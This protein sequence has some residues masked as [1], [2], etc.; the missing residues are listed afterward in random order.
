MAQPRF[1]SACGAA[2][3][4][5]PPVTCA[6]CGTSHWRNPKPCANAVVVRDGR[7]LLTRRAHQPWNGAW[8]CPGGFVERGEHPIEAAER[9]V[10]EETGVRVRVTGYLGVWVDDYADEP[11]DDDSE[12]INV[13]YYLAE[14]ISAEGGPDPAEV[15]EL[16]WFAWDELP[17]E[18]APPGT[19]EQVLAAA[20]NGVEL[21][22]RP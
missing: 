5:P 20:R 9:E 22:D 16:A 18:L 13:G 1:C 21:A 6:G 3:P 7:V 19:L 2:L 17:V 11:G 14:P 4:A 10:L 8:C 12:I 15:S